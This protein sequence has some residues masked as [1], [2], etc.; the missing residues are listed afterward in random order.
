MPGDIID[1]HHHLWNRERF[2]QPWIDPASMAAIDADFE[3]ADLA[4]EAK[5]SGVTG[6]VVVQ[7][8]HSEAET[9]DLLAVA[10]RSELIRGVVGWVD[11]TTPGVA[12]RIR[13]LQ[14][15]PGGGKLVGIRHLVQGEPD[16]AF[17]EY[18]T[19]RRALAAV[20]DA[21]LVFDLVIRHHQLPAAIR[22]VESLP[23][24]AFVLDHLGKP[25]L[26]T[27]DL[28][29]WADHLRTLAQLPNISAKLSGLATEANWS[30]WRPADLAP[31][32][33]QAL[34]TFGPSRLMF[35]SDWPVCLLATTYQGWID[36]VRGLL[37]G[38]DEREQDQIW[39][40]TAQRVYQLA[41][42]DR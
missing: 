7:T 2:P 15:G 6:T 29:E 12:D 14:G 34:E 9:I 35:G 18:D 1:A 27:G 32:V 37:A 22:L 3:P 21:G 38:C 24:V 17:L 11:L 10:A 8:I 33:S 20:A 23:Q 36:V 40:Q 26:A 25:P 41:A 28:R 30:S 19:I 5:P 4:L 39:R 42:S 13:R 31:A 16:P